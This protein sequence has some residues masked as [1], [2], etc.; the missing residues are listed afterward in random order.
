M[1]SAEPTDFGVRD[2]T[3]QMGSRWPWIAL[4]CIAL[5]FAFQVLLRA[6]ITFRFLPEAQI[7]GLH[8]IWDYYLMQW[9]LVARLLLLCTASYFALRVRGGIAAMSEGK[10]DGLRTVVTSLL[11]VALLLLAEDLAREL[12]QVADTIRLWALVFR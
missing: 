7:Q 8:T 9:R 6:A 2:G 11:V 1:D 12:G 3:Q 5:V 10:T 4:Q